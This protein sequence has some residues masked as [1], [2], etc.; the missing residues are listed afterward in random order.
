MPSKVP[1]M[2]VFYLVTLIII[3]T[4]LASCGRTEAEVDYNSEV[5][6][7]LSVKVERR[8]PLSQEEYSRMIGQNAA[9]LRYLIE[10]NRKIADLDADERNDA[11][12]NLLADP[13]YMERFGYLFTLG[14][15]LY[16][17]DADGKLDEHNRQLYA[18]LDEYNRRLAEYSE[19]N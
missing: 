7:D 1:T 12:R 14:S 4:L 11:W 2:K 3:S 10:E 17:A 8:E 18:G 6:E 15:A 13:D 9:I 5:C 16:Q 19:R